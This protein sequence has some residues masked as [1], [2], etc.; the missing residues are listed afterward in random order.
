MSGEPSER[1]AFLILNALPGVGPITLNRLLVEFGGDPRAVLAAD[2]RRL[3][4]IEGVRTVVGA[5][6]AAW[7]G[8]FNPEREE[9][10]LA[11]S[12][13]DFILPRDEAYPRLLR[14]IHDPPI[15]L[16]RK[17]AYAFGERCIAIVS[18]LQP[19]RWA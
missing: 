11:R 18:S 2:G 5:A 8:H 1:Q 17:G 4:G 15:G 13:A 12:G 16:Y 14:E 19:A 6:V 10:R 3:Q 7:R 9:D